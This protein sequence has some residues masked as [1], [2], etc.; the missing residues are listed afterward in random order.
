L[1]GIEHRFG[2]AWSKLVDGDPAETSIAAAAARFRRA[3]ETARAIRHHAGIWSR[4]I[5]PA[6]ERIKGLKAPRVCAAQCEQKSQA[7]PP[8]LLKES[9][10]FDLGIRLHDNAFPRTQVEAAM[11]VQISLARGEQS[12]RDKVPRNIVMRER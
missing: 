5:V 9:G 8:E 11:C 4:A 6:L 2:G 7:A 3:I 1:K 12:A 10:H